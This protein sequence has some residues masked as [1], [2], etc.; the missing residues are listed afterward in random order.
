MTYQ[1]DSV[2]SSSL[3]ECFPIAR[4]NKTKVIKKR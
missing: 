3:A 1:K 4:M 2:V